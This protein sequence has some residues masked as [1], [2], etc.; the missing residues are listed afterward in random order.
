MHKCQGAQTGCLFQ[1]QTVLYNYDVSKFF[2]F[3]LSL[4]MLFFSL[5]SD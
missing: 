3:F 4:Y 1:L 2:I 5:F